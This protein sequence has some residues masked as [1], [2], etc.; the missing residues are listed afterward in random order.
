MYSMSEFILSL[1]EVYVLHALRSLC[2]LQAQVYQTDRLVQPI[3]SRGSAARSAPYY[4]TRV[5]PV[6]AIDA[7]RGA[8]LCARLRA[9]LRKAYW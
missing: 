3:M 8:K 7:L 9:E 4:P 2:V 6:E 5:R 1:K